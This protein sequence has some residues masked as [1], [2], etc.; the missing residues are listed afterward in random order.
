MEENRTRIGLAG[1]RTIESSVYGG[2]VSVP[3]LGFNL[4]MPLYSA[5][6]A[7]AGHNV[8]L[9]RDFLKHFIVTFNGPTGWF[10]FFPAG[11]A[12]TADPY[13]DFAT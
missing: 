7:P 10:Q 13:D 5:D 4:P 6:F 2:I 11:P 12:A 9:G 3:E 8:L 1:G